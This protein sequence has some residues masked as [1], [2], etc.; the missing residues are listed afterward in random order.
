MYAPNAIVTLQEGALVGLAG[1]QHEQHFV[2]VGWAH[3]RQF[4]GVAGAVWRAALGL[5]LERPHR[6]GELL[7]DGI[8]VAFS[9]RGQGV[10]T[11]LLNAVYDFARQHG[12]TQVRLDVIDTNP[13]AR[14][15]YERHG[16]QA[17]HTQP[18]GILKPLFGFASATEMVK[19]LSE[20]P[21]IPPAPAAPVPHESN[22]NR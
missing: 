11:L 16:F 3:L 15:L 5:L 4:H 19:C 6:S 17:T 13:D 7:M 2:N 10:G 14:R 9:A 1:M 22:A 21:A 8:A 20:P 18:L 12:Y